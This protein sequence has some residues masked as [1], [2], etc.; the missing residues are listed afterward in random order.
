MYLVNTSEAFDSI[1]QVTINGKV[2]LYTHLFNQ[3]YPE[4]A[5]KS[6]F[7]PEYVKYFN[8]FFLV[9]KRIISS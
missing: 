7:T 3:I 9:N 8:K 1:R 6:V 4:Q 2:I 5:G